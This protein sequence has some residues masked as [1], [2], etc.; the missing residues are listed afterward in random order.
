MTHTPGPWTISN[1]IKTAINSSG[2]HVAMVNFGIGISNEE[3][4]ANVALIAAA[5]DLL[6][7]LE[8]VEWFGGLGDVCPKCRQRKPKGHADDCQL[9]LALA[10]ARSE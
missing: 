3:H 2:K 5:P 4:N 6:A 7:A 1:A 9:A 10:K 8:A